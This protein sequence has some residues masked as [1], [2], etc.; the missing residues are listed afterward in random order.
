MTLYE[1]VLLKYSVTEVNKLDPIDLLLVISNALAESAAAAPPP[2]LPNKDGV[3]V[4][5][6][7]L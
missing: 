7:M 1:Y 2:G 5:D 4:D 6:M 3:T